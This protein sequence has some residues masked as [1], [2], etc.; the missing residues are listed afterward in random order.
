MQDGDVES[1]P[2]PFQ[3]QKVIFGSFN[4]GDTE[5]FGET[6]GIQCSCNALLAI[7]WASIKRVSVWKTY[8]LDN[9]LNLGNALYKN[10]GM[11]RSLALVELPDNVEIYEHQIQVFKLKNEYGMLSRI[12]FKNT[13]FIHESMRNCED[14]GNGLLFLTNGYTF[15][16][17]W[18]KQ[19]YFLFDSHSHNKEGLMADDGNSIL[20]EFRSTNELLEYIQKVYLC[21]FEEAQYEL[22]YIKIERSEDSRDAISLYAKRLRDCERKHLKRKQNSNCKQALEAERKRKKD[23]YDR[24]VGTEQHQ[25]VKDRMRQYSKSKLDE[26][27]G[28]EKQE[29][30]KQEQRQHS[31]LT[32][33]KVVGTE[34]HE[35]LK[36]RMRQYSKVHFDKVTGTDQYEAEKEHKRQSSRARFDKV[37]GTEEYELVKERMRQYSKKHF[38]EVTSTEEYEAE[39]E[40][41]RQSSRAR[42][43]K[44]IGT[45]NHEANKERM[46]QYSKVRFSNVVGTD[47]HKLQLSV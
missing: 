5:R 19:N 20:L 1:N 41:K 45:E 13:D 17:I 3:V 9:I 28:T 6:A 46:R 37:V 32:F 8:D 30:R 42:F 35:L 38:D 12:I 34:E 26:I 22:Q 24:I 4:Q 33:D 27:V 44:L 14:T 23:Y 7:C 25:V 16:I 47:V 36:E 40:N 29:A 2:G 18:A 39:N 21:N 31:K 11:N 10:I 15:A 43:D